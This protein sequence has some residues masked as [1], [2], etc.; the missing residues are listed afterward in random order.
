MAIYSTGQSDSGID[1]A[2]Q[3]ALQAE[4]DDELASGELWARE[5]ES[6]PEP[7]AEVGPPNRPWQRPV[8]EKRQPPSSDSSLW[9][10]LVTSVRDRLGGRT[11][12]WPG[13]LPAAG[14]RP[15]D[16]RKVVPPIDSTAY[17]AALA[18]N[19][20]KREDPRKADKQA[21][22]RWKRDRVGIVV[23]HGIGP[24]LAGQTLLDWTR[25]IITAVNDAAT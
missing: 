6:F 21:Y 9:S 1:R 10:M 3:L 7:I 13:S 2:L 4:L 19:F 14:Q 12:E 17:D 25:P 24:Q 11:T 5:R 23:V 8:V 22:M 16:S 20:P 15:E 18:A